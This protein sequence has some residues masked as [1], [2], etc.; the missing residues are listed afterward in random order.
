MPMHTNTTHTL[1][2]TI[3]H[4]STVEH[5]MQSLGLICV[6]LWVRAL[7]GTLEICVFLWRKALVGTLEN[8]FPGAKHLWGPWKSAYFSG[9]EHSWGPCESLCF[10]AAKHLW[11]PRKSACF[12]GDRG[13]R[14]LLQ[15][16]GTSPFFGVRGAVSETLGE[17]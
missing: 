6:F 8:C 7:V 11:G 1:V 5:T 12:S 16:A 9:Q 10:S 15:C 4:Q 14:Q 17:V 3:V 2:L 13:P